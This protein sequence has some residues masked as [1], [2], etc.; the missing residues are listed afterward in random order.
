MPK[1][2]GKMAI[3]RLSG[4]SSIK[5]RMIA[6]SALVMLLAV[7]GAMGQA[8]LHEG[9]GLQGRVLQTN[10]TPAPFCFQS[11]QVRSLISL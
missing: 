4:G 10:P 3:A 2:L 6:G 11:K 5:L 1:L 8:R 7:G 9:Q